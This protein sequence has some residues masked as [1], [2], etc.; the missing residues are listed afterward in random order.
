L[1]P[2]TNLL[3]DDLPPLAARVAGL[4]IGLIRKAR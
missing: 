3:A 4:S 2:T 1:L